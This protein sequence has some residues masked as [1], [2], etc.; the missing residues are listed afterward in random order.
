[1]TRESDFFSLS[2][3]YVVL[4]DNG[5][6]TPIAVSDRFFADLESKFGDFKGKRLISHFTFDRDW[7]TWEMHPAG[8]EFICLLSGQVDLILE[9]DGIENTVHLNAPGSFALVP[10]GTWHTAR[11]YTPSSMLFITPGEGTQNRP[12]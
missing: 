9:Q 5:K 6:A 3:T 11:V 12:L 8:E 1:M 7:N 4:G 2:S 10:R